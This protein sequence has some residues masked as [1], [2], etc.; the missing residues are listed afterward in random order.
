MKGRPV[1]VSITTLST[2]PASRGRR[3]GALGADAL[4]QLVG[5]ALDQADTNAGALGE[6]VIQRAVGVSVAGGVEVQHPLL[7]FRRGGGK[8]G[9][10]LTGSS[11]TSSRRPP[12]RSTS[13]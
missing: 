5:V 3:F 12:L 6:A 11:M 1:A 2:L 10:G 7:R 13:F 9:V 4:D 8:C